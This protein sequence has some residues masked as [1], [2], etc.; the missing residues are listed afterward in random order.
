MTTFAPSDPTSHT[1]PASLFLALYSTIPDSKVHGANVGPIWGRQDP[2]GPHVGPMNLALW[3]ILIMTYYKFHGEDL[4]A[5][6][7]YISVVSMD[8]GN[9]NYAYFIT[10]T[11]A[12]FIERSAM[13]D[14]LFDS[15]LPS[16]LL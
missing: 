16:A 3:D 1:Q 10:F 15:G 4:L 2:G 13:T 11:M 5:N 12:L 8:F 7:Y 6:L 9:W 14:I